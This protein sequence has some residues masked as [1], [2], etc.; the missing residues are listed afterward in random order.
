MALG[1]IEYLSHYWAAVFIKSWKFAPTSFYFSLEFCTLEEAK[2]KQTKTLHKSSHWSWSYW[3]L[4]RYA[5]HWRTVGCCTSLLISCKFPFDS[6]F[7]PLKTRTS[8]WYSERICAAESTRVTFH[9]LNMKDCVDKNTTWECEHIAHNP[10]GPTRLAASQSHRRV[11]KLIG[12][13]TETPPTSMVQ[14][15]RQEEGR[16]AAAD[17]TGRTA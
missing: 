1:A 11:L 15:K 9:I 14:K 17:G 10:R 5:H 13:R 6:L 12:T 4:D 3:Y 16:R 2:N 7:A 8:S